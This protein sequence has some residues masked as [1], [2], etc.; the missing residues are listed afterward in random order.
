[1]K[2]VQ[3]TENCVEKQ[4]CGSDLQSVCWAG[5]VTV[6]YR[7]CLSVLQVVVIEFKT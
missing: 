3:N 2:I 1:M 7:N 6:F 5:N 4:K